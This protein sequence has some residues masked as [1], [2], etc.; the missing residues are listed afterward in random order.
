MTEHVHRWRVEDVYHDYGVTWEI[1]CMESDCDATLAWKEVARR[2][3]AIERLGAEMRGWVHPTAEYDDEF[4][5]VI[6]RWTAEL[7][8]TQQ[9]P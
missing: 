4:V 2:L 8:G 3:N 7:E 5:E 1:L 6:R 9:L